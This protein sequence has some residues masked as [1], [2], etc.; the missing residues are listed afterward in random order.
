MINDDRDNDHDSHRRLSIFKV[1]QE[2]DLEGLIELF[3]STASSSVTDDS[4]ENHR[5]TVITDIVDE[6][7]CTL[8]HHAAGNGSVPICQWLLEQSLLLLPD[9]KQEKQDH[10]T[11]TK[12]SSSHH[13]NRRGDGTS[14]SSTT[15]TA[16]AAA[17]ATH[18]QQFLYAKS[19]RH[20]RTALHWAA[21]NG[22]DGCCR[23]LVRRWKMDV[24][25]EA[26][27]GVTPLELSVWQRHLNTCQTLVNELG[28]DPFHT[29]SWGCGL[30]HW[31]GKSVSH[32]VDDDNDDDDNLGCAALDGYDTSHGSDDQPVFWPGT[33]RSEKLQQTTTWQLCEWLHCHCKLDLTRLKQNKYG[34]TCLHKAAY[35]GNVIVCIYLRYK[36]RVLDDTRDQQHN[37]AAD[38]AER[39]NKTKV[40]KWLRR[41][42]SPCIWTTALDDLGLSKM[43]KHCEGREDETTSPVPI[44]LPSLG[45]IRSAYLATV[46][47][48]HPDCHSKA[49]V[50]DTLSIGLSVDPNHDSV[51]LDHTNPSWYRVQDAYELLT[52]WWLDPQLSDGQI[53]QRT[54][55]IQLQANVPLLKWNM[56][57]HHQ[58][59]Q[60]QKRLRIAEYGNI[61]LSPSR[62]DFQYPTL[63]ENESNST[64][65]MTEQ[66]KHTTHTIS[67]E[68]MERLRGFELHLV[69]LLSSMSSKAP[70]HELPLSQLPKEYRKV[71]GSTGIISKYPIPKPRDYRCKRLS[72]VLENF[73]QGC[74]EVIGVGEA[75]GVQRVRLVRTSSNTTQLPK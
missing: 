12:K 22:H 29:N 7:G 41:Y 47:E 33:M 60:Q 54:R 71:W 11:T 69:K 66:R 31:L 17:A 61:V 18:V 5:S 46:K 40:A 1:V 43:N 70:H 3:S 26:K 67:S 55:Y 45:E 9:E 21:R 58:Y 42:T 4:E 34:Q 39:N 25:V 68:A 35:E 16:A 19:R 37:L 65:E 24:N 13:N 14:S 44:K 27:G 75:N 63:A 53:R 56:E 10:Q 15:T 28:A 38:C 50:D 57:W 36:C 52:T 23:L 8:L 30:T 74:I 20:G 2:G 48:L 62:N 6:Q 73:C 32:V 72:H 59:E 64:L 51:G 49:T